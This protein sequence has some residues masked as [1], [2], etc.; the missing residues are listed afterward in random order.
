[1]PHL[2]TTYAAVNSLI[3]I[4]DERV[5]SSINR[6]NLYSF[7][8][9]IKDL[10]GGFRLHYG[11][12]LDVRA[13]YTTI[14]VASVLNILD[15]ELAQGVG[16][17]ILRFVLWP[18]CNKDETYGLFPRLLIFLF[19]CG[20]AGEPWFE[21]YGGFEDSD[22]VYVEDYST[23]GW[24]ENWPIKQEECVKR[25]DFQTS[26]LVDTL[27][28]LL[29]ENSLFKNEVKEMKSEITGLRED[30]VM[31]KD[32]EERMINDMTAM[33]IHMGGMSKAIQRIAS[34]YPQAP[35]P[36][37]ATHD[38]APQDDAPPPPPAP[39]DDAPL[40]EEREETHE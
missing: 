32:K 14:S 13:C 16:N 35:P 3:T 40:E 25:A 10:S 20:I 11:G 31:M 18:N 12:E 19:S 26:E 5:L 2:A 4:G 29:E 1:M 8:L 34:Y 39:L 24:C 21:A 17:Y 23:R 28:M 22:E 9:Q 30:V 7:L 6:Q 38:D 37:A 33:R 27:K 15:N 36:Q